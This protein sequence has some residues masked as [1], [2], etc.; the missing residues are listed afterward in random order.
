VPRHEHARHRHQRG[1]PADRDPNTAPTASI[2]QPP[3]ARST[4]PATP[5]ATR[6]RDRPRG[7]HPRRQRVHLA[8]GLPSRHPHAPVRAATTAATSGSFTIPTSARPSANVWYRIHLTVRDSGGLTHRD[9]PDVL[10]RKA[11]VTL[12]TSPAGLQL[13][14]DGQPQTAPTTFTGVPAS[15][16]A[17][18]RRPRRPWAARPT[19]LTRGPTEGHV[20]TTSRPPRRTRPTPRRSTW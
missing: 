15:Y 8:G 16:E 6:E 4:R 3:A 14:L 10:P 7:R 9:H 19:R 5:I 17:W 1:G 2:T 18:R 20:G 12:Q 13:L 11:D